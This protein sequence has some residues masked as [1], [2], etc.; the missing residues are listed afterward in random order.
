[1]F[2]MDELKH[3]LRAEWSNVNHAR[4]SQR[5][6]TCIYPKRRR[7]QWRRRL[8]AC[9]KAGASQFEHRF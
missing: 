7:V 9:V 4:R 1:M 5:I 6:R 3:R 2:D 8:F